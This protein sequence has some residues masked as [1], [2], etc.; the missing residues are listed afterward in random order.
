MN[1]NLV[2]GLVIALMVVAA[3]G[4]LVWQHRKGISSCGCKDCNC[5]G[6][7]S[8]VKVEDCE[9]CQCCKKNDD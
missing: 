4:Y 5:C 8:N 6:A 1:G 2:V 3:V 9:N 7:C